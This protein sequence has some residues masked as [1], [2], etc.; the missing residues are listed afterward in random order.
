MRSSPSP[1]WTSIRRA[2]DAFD[3]PLALAAL[4]TMTSLM[5]SVLLSLAVAHRRLLP[6]QAWAAAHVDEDFQMEVWGGD[7]EAEE[8]RARRWADMKAAA[9]LLSLRD[10]A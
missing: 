6:E 10:Q 8:R 1:P 2:V 9:E 5:G 4:A 7:E 3:D